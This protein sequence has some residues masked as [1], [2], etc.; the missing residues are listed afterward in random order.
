MY[1]QTVSSASKHFDTVKKEQKGGK[2]ISEV[3]KVKMKQLQAILHFYDYSTDWWAYSS[4]VHFKFKEFVL[5][6]CPDCYFYDTWECLVY[7]LTFYQT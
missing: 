5:A 7:Y 1:L 2:R 6:F 4:L 3:H